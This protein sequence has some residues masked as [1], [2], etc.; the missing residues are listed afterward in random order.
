MT[1]PLA[2]AKHPRKVPTNWQELSPTEQKIMKCIWNSEFGLKNSE[3]SRRIGVSRQAASY[4][5]KMLVNFGWLTK[6]D[7]LFYEKISKPDGI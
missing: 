4:R 3:I 6:V 1:K 5:S 2:Y 7:G